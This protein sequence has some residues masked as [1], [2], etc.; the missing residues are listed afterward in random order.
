MALHRT[1][2]AL[3][4]AG[5]ALHRA[6]VVPHRAGVALHRAGVA[7]HRA[8]V[9]LHRAGVVPH[10]AGVALHRAGVAL[11]RA[12]VAL[13]W[14]GVAPHRARVA[15]IDCRIHC[16]PIDHAEFSSGRNHLINLW[17]GNCCYVDEFP[18]PFP[19]EIHVHYNWNLTSSEFGVVPVL[20]LFTGRFRH[21]AASIRPIKGY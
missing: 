15:I 3:H 16:F 10:R 11:H 14:A 12:G 5:V 9:A 1:G 7:L 17:P 18:L 21:L 13:H 2:V 19:Q 8:G 20:N 4:R 6:G